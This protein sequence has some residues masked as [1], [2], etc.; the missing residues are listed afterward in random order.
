MIKSLFLLLLRGK[1]ELFFPK[2]SK[3]ELISPPLSDQILVFYKPLS[4]DQQLHMSK[5]NH[6]QGIYKR[7]LIK[8]PLKIC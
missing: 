2:K 1:I 5:E 8:L 4:L 7:Y 3:Y 6:L